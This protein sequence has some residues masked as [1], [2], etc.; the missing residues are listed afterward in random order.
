MM[1]SHTLKGDY[2]EEWRVVAGTSEMIEVSNL[3]RVRSLMRGGIPYILKTQ[4]DEKG[5]HRLRVTI[6]RKK[7]SFKL[8]RIVAGAFIENPDNLP[9]VNHIDGNKDNNSADNLEWISNRDNAR[10]AIANGLWDSVIDGSRRENERRMKGIIA[11]RG[12]EILEFES[13]SEAERFF[14]SRHIVDVLKGRRQS[15]KG[16]HFSYKEGGDAI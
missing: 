12:D 1:N 10:H 7:M 14:G 15:C 11:T 13:V 3:G 16:Y 9:Q 6:N 2:M 5:Y 8:H 4:K